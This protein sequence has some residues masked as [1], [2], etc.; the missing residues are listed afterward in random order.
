MKLITCILIV[1]S[2]F[3]FNC[4]ND[5]T[6]SK[7]SIQY[8]IELFEGNW[9]CSQ[10]GVSYYKNGSLTN[11]Y[12]NFTP[13]STSLYVSIDNDTAEIFD[14]ADKTTNNYMH[15]TQGISVSSDTLIFTAS[16][17][18]N[19]RVIE[20]YN[21]NS[22]KTAYHY[23]DGTKEWWIMSLYNGDVVPPVNWPQ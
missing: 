21:G 16:F 17:G 15:I 12:E 23:D 2:L 6:S 22:F 9:Y 10:E 13:T 5:L 7:K 1:V 3:L 18:T 14:H 19:R 8:N 11:E 20:E 4:D